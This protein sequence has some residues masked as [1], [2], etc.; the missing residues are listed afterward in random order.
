RGL[1]R[2]GLAA[3]ALA[4]AACAST[5]G[6]EAPRGGAAAT[7]ERTAPDPATRSIAT[8]P[9]R[10]ALLL[11]LGATA[12]RVRGDAKAIEN[13]ARLAL[14]GPDGAAV[15]LSVHDTR[16]EPSVAEA[17]VRRALADGAE[18]II[19]PLFAG[20]TRAVAGPAQA[21]G[22]PVLSFSTDTSAAGSGVWVTG[23]TPENEVAR[24]MAYAAANQ[25]TRIGVYAPDVPYG[26]AA[27]RGIDRAAATAG[28]SIAVREVYPRS[29][30]DIQRTAP[31]FVDRARAAG[32]DA[33]LIPDFGQGLTTATSFLDFAGLPQPG[34]RYLGLG[35]WESGSTLRE[36][37][38]LGGWFAGADT[39]AKQ[40]F[41]AAYEARYGVRP[42]FVAVLGYDAASVAAELAREAA[43]APVDGP[44]FPAEALTR[45]GGFEG[46][47]GAL[48]LRPDGTTERGI[49]VLEVG[50]RVFNVLEP[51][52]ARFPAGS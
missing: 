26:Q 11:P 18:L 4:L 51:A 22:V 14:T 12:D 44:R 19:G 38:I 45:G 6:R 13:A 5:P 23:F 42:P 25:I 2:M 20:A 27:M 33:V 1:G 32:V 47:V 49:A 39:E 36:P 34:V 24:I 46:A 8:G 50:N 10:V 41:F 40:R 30:Q 31:G 7:P 17:A 43:R 48:A 28:V 3:L 29:F 35:Q 21:A 52:P 37:T 9:A 16:G 15:R